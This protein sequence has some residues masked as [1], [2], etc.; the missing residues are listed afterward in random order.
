[1]K[2]GAF[3][4]AREPGGITAVIGAMFE[5]VARLK[6]GL[7]G[8]TVAFGPFEIHSGHLAGVRVLLAESGVGKVN[9]AAI[10]QELLARGADRVVFTGV[11][12][13]LDPELR[14]L[15]VVIGSSAVQHDVDVTGLG[16]RPGEVPGVGL[17]FD[18]DPKL[19][20]LA[21][22]V[23]G[24]VVAEEAVAGVEAPPAQ[25]I[26]RV[27]VARIASGDA[28]VADPERA[29]AIRRQFDAACA[30]MEGAACAQVCTRWGAPFV[31]VRSISDGADNSAE[32]NFR[33]FTELAARRAEA[34]VTGMLRE[35][36]PTAGAA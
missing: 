5:E 30:E 22:T 32:L 4:G 20:A 12:G 25:P 31:I 35:L 23:A 21:T 24:K 36:G 2:R 14:P 1:M 28:F 33:R 16:Y 9:A 11:A 6:S 8:E 27:V 3:A 26:A 17:V 13:A 15:D 29:A 19:V 7:R 34:I 10:T 18:A